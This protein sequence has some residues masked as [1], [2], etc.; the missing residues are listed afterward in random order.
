MPPEQLHGGQLGPPTDVFAVAA[1]LYEAW[2]GAAPFRRET[3]EAS[4]R[5]LSE[6]VP[7][8]STIDRSSLRSTR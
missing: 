1:L 4:E 6:R 3:P 2:T 5:A 7:T 8:L